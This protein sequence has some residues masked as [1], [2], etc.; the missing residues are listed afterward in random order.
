MPIRN[1]EK[2]WVPSVWAMERNP[3]WPARPPPNL[4]WSR[5]GSRSSSSCAMTRRERSSSDV[6]RNSGGSAAP[7][8]FMNVVGTA[9]VIGPR[10]VDTVALSARCRLSCVSRRPRRSATSRTASP[11]TLC[12]EPSKS[13]PGLAS[14]MMTSVLALPRRSWSRKRRSATTDYSATISVSVSTATFAGA[15]VRPGRDVTT[16][17]VGSPAGST[18]LGSSSSSTRMVPP[19]LRSEMSTSM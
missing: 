6:R 8:S 18:P 9:R 7:D 10:S 14:P 11:P 19:T 2:S 13:E 4:N 1:R 17:T 16:E 5:P 15:V 3:L 12:R